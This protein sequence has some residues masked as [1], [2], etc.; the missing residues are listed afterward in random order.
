MKYLITFSIIALLVQ[1]C[2][3]IQPT[4]TPTYNDGGYNFNK[5]NSEN[6]LKQDS[7]IV[8]GKVISLNKADTNFF[9]T[10]QLGCNKANTVNSVG[11]YKLKLRPSDYKFQLTA[12]SL[13]Y[14][15][16]ETKPFATIAGD[17][18]IVN[19]YLEE[20]KRPLINCE[21]NY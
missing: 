6:L 21:G 1:G 13:G 5:F 17:S 18:I 3:N 16:V 19:F 20:D 7:I 10:V 9:A 15:I 12:I 4:L 11:N 2:F 14:L 8:S